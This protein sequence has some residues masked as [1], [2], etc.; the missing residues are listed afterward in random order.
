MPVNRIRILVGDSR[1]AAVI[2][3]VALPLAR[4]TNAQAEYRNLDA[5]FPV[6]IE[7][8][9]VTDRYDVD[10]DLLNVPLRR[11]F[12]TTMEEW[13]AMADAMGLSKMGGAAPIG[14]LQ[15]R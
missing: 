11:A 8:A 6:R 1:W 12:G 9:T 15:E 3:L 2:L 5:G 4:E 10:L 14:I 13:K 7:D